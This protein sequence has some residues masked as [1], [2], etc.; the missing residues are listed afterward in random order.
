MIDFVKQQAFEEQQAFVLQ[1]EE[2][3]CIKNNFN[4]TKLQ[5]LY[6]ENRLF[7]RE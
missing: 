5:N 3:S 1:Q 7:L 4:T 6:Y 2:F